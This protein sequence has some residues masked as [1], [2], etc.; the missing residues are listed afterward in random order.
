MKLLQ[1]LWMAILLQGHV[2]E[3]LVIRPVVSALRC[4]DT[5][6]ESS[7]D[8]PDEHRS[9]RRRFVGTTTAAIVSGI[10]SHDTAVATATDDITNIEKCE[11]PPNGIP[12]CVSTA[13]VK[14]VDLYMAPWTWYDDISSETILARLKGAIAYDPTLTIVDQTSLSLIVEGKRNFAIDRIVFRVNPNDRAVT[15]QSRQIEGP[16]NVSDFGAN[17]K[18]L[19]QL[20]K[21]TQILEIM[22]SEFASADAGRREGA[23]DQ[24]RAFWGFQSGGGYESVLL[25]EI[26]D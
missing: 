12:N 3:S 15:F 22:G 1:P 7:L 26:D 14:Q 23:A 2:V 16:E 13:S 18:R 6:I 5:N 10:L 19:E 9:S 21:K 17:R 25:D 8:D 20:R 24:L 4:R 11:K